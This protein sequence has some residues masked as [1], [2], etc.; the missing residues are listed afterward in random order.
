M[1]AP[2]L[3]RAP[4]EAA[5]A[6][7]L[8]YQLTL[9]GARA[10]QT[11]YATARYVI[12]RVGDQILLFDRDRAGRFLV[13]V[14][15]R[16]L[17]PIDETAQIALADAIRAELDG[18]SADRDEPGAVIAGLP[19][20]R[21]C[22]R[23]DHPRVVASGEVFVARLPGAEHTAL[24][25]DRAAQARTQPFMLPLD[26]GEIVTSSRV[27]VLAHHLDLVQTLTLE[28]VERGI[29]DRSQIEAYL[30]YCVVH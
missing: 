19:C 22:V 26:P 13:D 16:A 17:R 7:T 27:R 11:Q 1:L 28:R 8:H 20:S 21:F 12:T 3:Q 18:V 6:F 15:A 30:D 25:E 10:P 29:A 9:R 5:T 2:T 24:A 23:I 14:A 4:S